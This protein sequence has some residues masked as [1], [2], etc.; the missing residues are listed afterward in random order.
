MSVFQANCPRCGTKSVAFTIHDERIWS[1]SPSVMW[2]TFAICGCCG[3]GVIATFRSPGDHLP[4]SMCL[5]EKQLGLSLIGIAP[6]LPSTGAPQHT[7]PNVARS[8]EQAKDNLPK[9]RDA[10]GM[11]FR[12]ALDTGLKHKFPDLKEEK[13]AV[14]IKKAA[15]AHKLTPDLADW[16]H[17]IRIDGNDAT[18]EEEEVS[19]ETV[20]SLSTLTEMVLLYLFTLPGMLEEA[21]KRAESS[22]SEEQPP[23]TRI[24]RI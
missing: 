15:E 13:L 9:N 8:F 18:H 10:A 7:P 5:K 21:R 11:M 1:Y 23:P 12:K 2:D 16:A 4:P 6:D 24:S 19:P 22:T 17:Q 14:R 3:R 20:E